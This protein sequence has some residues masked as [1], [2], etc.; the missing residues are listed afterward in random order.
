MK[1]YKKIHAMAKCRNCDWS[2]GD[3]TIAQIEAKKHCKETNHLVDVEI[4]Y[5]RLFINKQ[6]KQEAFK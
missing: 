1:G 4:G 6:K 2:N 3:F 5:W